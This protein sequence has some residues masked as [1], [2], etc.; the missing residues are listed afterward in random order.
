MKGAGEHININMHA[1]IMVLKDYVVIID[2][3]MHA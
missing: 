1:Y 2:I 3:H